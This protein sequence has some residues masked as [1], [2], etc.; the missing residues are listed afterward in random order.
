MLTEQQLSFWNEN[1]PSARYPGPMGRRIDFFPGVKTA[2]KQEVAPFEDANKKGAEV[3]QT[4]RHLETSE[5]FLSAVQNGQSTRHWHRRGA[6][7]K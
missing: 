3:F 6:R 7:G 1:C 2:H 5:P 4:R